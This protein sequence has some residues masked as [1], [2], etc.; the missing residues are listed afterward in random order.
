MFNEQEKFI[1]F[2]VASGFHERAKARVQFLKEL[3]KKRSEDWGFL[4]NTNGEYDSHGIL[5]QNH[6]YF[7]YARPMRRKSEYDLIG[8]ELF[9]ENYIEKLFQ[10]KVDQPVI[11]IDLGGMQGRSWLRLAK[12]FEKEVDNSKIAFIVTNL[13]YDPKKWAE[14]KYP[15]KRYGQIMEESGHLVHFL[16]LTVYKARRTS[17]QLKNG[18][19]VPLQGNTD[20]VNERF[21]VHHWSYVPEIEIVEA[22]SL[23]SSFG[24][25]VID[26]GDGFLD[27]LPNVYLSDGDRSQGIVLAHEEICK[28][29]GLLNITNVEKG[30]YESYNFGL[31][32]FFYLFRK[33]DA[34]PVEANEIQA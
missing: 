23:L 3:S 27:P 10:K 12:R 31:R 22:A 16:N 6:E 24:I 8:M 17:I 9:F 7:S 18:R 13:A 15:S 2:P 21:S 33:P 32:R 25:Y 5:R 34:P 11:A 14:E 1:G 26:G 4:S 19:K 30:D 28:R 20:I 29:F